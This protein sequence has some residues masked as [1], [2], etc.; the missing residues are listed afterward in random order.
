MSDSTLLAPALSQSKTHSPL[1]EARAVIEAKMLRDIDINDLRRINKLGLYNANDI[2][3]FDP[4]KL[5][6]GKTSP[7]IAMG[8]TAYQKE[9]PSPNASAASD[10]KVKATLQANLAQLI[11]TELVSTADDKAVAKA[12]SDLI[13]NAN[14]QTLMADLQRLKD[15]EGYGSTSVDPGVNGFDPGINGNPSCVR[16]QQS[17]IQRLPTHK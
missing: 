5:K 6:P 15:Y 9:S 3:T 17:G 4:A 16:R 8:N 12:L 1:D 14:P 2:A 11:T 7:D 10:D 13:G